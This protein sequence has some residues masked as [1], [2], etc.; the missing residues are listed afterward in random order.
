MKN[1]LLILTI[2]FSSLAFSGER[3]LILSDSHFYGPHSLDKSVMTSFKESKTAFKVSLGDVF[4]IKWT[5]KKEIKQALKD[6]KDFSDFCFQK[7][8]YEIDGNHDLKFIG[9]SYLIKNG[10]LFTHGH[11]VSWDAKTIAKK[12]KASKDGVSK[13]KR[14]AFGALVNA[15]PYGHLSKEEIQKAAEL[16]KLHKCHTIIFGHTH[17]KELIDIKFD[18]IRIINVPRGI[19]EIEV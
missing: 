14:N 7:G 18:G 6:Q 12:E 5:L 15:K 17:V 13:I 2:L 3:V 4:D 10:V 19:T 8:I 11:Y 1:L 9:H 16:A